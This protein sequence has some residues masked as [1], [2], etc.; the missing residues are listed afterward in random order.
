MRIPGWCVGIVVFAL[1]VVAALALRAAWHEEHRLDRAR[2]ELA[3]T[4]HQLV[5]MHRRVTRAT[6]LARS[7][8]TEADVLESDR[9]ATRAV[10]DALGRDLG[11]AGGEFE[12]ARRQQATQ[13][14]HL[15]SVQG[16]LGGVRLALDRTAAGDPAGAVG[17]LR[18]AAAACET[19]ITS[20]GPDAPVFAF[21]FA[22]PFV[23]RAGGE[24]YAFATNAGGG[25]V[26]A[27]QSADLARWELRGNALANLPSWAVPN[28][29]WAPAVLARGGGY[30]LYYTVREASTNR[31]C[32]SAAIGTAPAGP[33]LDPSSAP[34]TCGSSEALDPSP[35]VD[36]DGRA[37]LHWKSERPARVWSAPLTG[38]GR[39]LAG[40]PRAI[41]GSG[42]SWE[43][44]NVEAPSMLRTA[45]GYW[46][47][48]SGNDWNGR[49]YAQGLARC[50][51]PLGPCGEVG[52]E[53]FLAS[54]GSIGGP[55]GGS[56][57]TDALGGV[58]LAYH[59]Y[60]E[61]AVGYPNSRL[62][63]LAR[64][65]ADASGTPVVVPR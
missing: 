52:S 13:H 50:R 41:L 56:V 33:Y 31:Q 20:G 5:R 58:W 39:A 16:C 32:L 44:G 22:D 57:F 45:S 65:G 18:A 40:T 43:A 15:V 37:Y 11:A 62:L 25:S 23:L 53:P 4:R 28:H 63:H 59:A 9:S 46:L 35:F 38:D 3:D 51:G 60:L 10:V 55:G 12:L 47:F 14:A 2:R 48:F 17:G 7:A 24:Y 64:L 19:A 1:V 26:Q 61:P 36:D 6:A 49:R 30:V 42:R 21:D 54:H 27:I 8:R 29:T 34:L